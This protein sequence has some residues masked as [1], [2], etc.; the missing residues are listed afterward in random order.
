MINSI[1]KNNHPTQ[2]ENQKSALKMVILP[3]IGLIL[4]VFIISMLIFRQISINQ[5]SSL[6]W[7][8]IS[9]IIIS[10]FLFIP[11]IFLLVLILGLIIVINKSRQPIQS[12][13][14]KLRYYVFISSKILVNI[15][16][17]LLKPFVYLESALSFFY[18]QKN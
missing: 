1:E 17:I 13:F 15:T 7:V 5:Q 10:I 2:K 4:L 8:N 16:K 3:L 9:L 11:G 18:K 14:W 6:N 12:G